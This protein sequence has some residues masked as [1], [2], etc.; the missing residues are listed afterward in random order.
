MKQVLTTFGLKN[1]YQYALYVGYPKAL[2]EVG[3]RANPLSSIGLDPINDL[4]R[5]AQVATDCV[6]QSDAVMIC[7]GLDVEPLRYGQERSPFVTHLDPARDEL[8][9]AVINEAIRQNKKI[10]AICR[11]IQILN[12]T[13]GGSLHQDLESI[14]LTGHGIWDRENDLVHS[15]EIDPTSM[16]AEVTGAIA[17][18]NSLHHQGIKDLAPTLKASAWSH[19]DLI[20]AVE[21]EK[22][23]GV[24]WHPERLY[25][26][27]VANL[28]LFEWL[29]S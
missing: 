27:E 25:Q 4:D 12:V 15:I 18:V 19:D 9:I 23:I 28:A 22:I 2:A 1:D 21:G 13:L 16:L 5:I 26:K 3:A 10:L 17:G 11:G 20:E 14:G 8:E 6:T 29:V 24:Q 7:G